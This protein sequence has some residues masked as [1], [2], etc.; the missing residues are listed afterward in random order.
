MTW[1]ISKIANHYGEY[2]VFDA[3]GNLVASS[4][5]SKAHAEMI[6][7][8]P[9]VMDALADL[10]EDLEQLSDEFAICKEIL[11]RS[12]GTAARAAIKKV[13]GGE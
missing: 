8:I 13:R 6:A 1:T 5:Q 9:D 3:A 7:A 12:Y 4:V 10:V 2:M 11:Q